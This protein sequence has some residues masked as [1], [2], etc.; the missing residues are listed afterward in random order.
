MIAIV[1]SL[2]KSLLGLY[3][4]SEIYYSSSMASCSQ[5]QWHYTLIVFIFNFSGVVIGAMLAM[6]TLQQILNN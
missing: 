6:H 4:F 5:F 1:S 2:L 3:L